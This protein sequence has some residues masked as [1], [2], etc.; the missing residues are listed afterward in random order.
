MSNR[1]EGLKI[2]INW[3]KLEIKRSEIGAIEYAR[4]GGCDEGESNPYRDAARFHEYSIEQLEKLL[5]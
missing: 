2:A 4:Q 5:R 3:H 1:N